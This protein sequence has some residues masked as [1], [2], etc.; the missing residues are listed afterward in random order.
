M[1]SFHP[2]CFRDFCE[3][4]IEKI[5]S[6]SFKGEDLI[7]P[8]YRPPLDEPMGVSQWKYKQDKIDKDD[9]SQLEG[10][11]IDDIIKLLTNK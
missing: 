9:L 2:R 4:G 3:M 10:E 5:D 8:V 7:E 11:I 1:Y 6:H